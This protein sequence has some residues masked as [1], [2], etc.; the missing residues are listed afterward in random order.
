MI[1]GNVSLRCEAMLPLVV[2]SANGQQQVIDA[3]IDTGFNGFLTLPSEIIAKLDLSW[4]GSD[5]VTLGD[6]SET[7]FDIYSA[8]IIWDGQFRE[9]D[10]AESETEP[11]I[12]MGLLYG[13]KLQI[14]VIERGLVTI[15]ALA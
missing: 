10:I 4:N 1:L 11:L 13:Y 2:D 15:V 9:V 12:G 7:L 6:G 5:T 8:R 3:V 14:E